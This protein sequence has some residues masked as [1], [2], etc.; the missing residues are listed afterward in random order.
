M[1]ER[2]VVRA[3]PLSVQRERIRRRRLSHVVI[4]RHEMERDGVVDHRAYS[5][6]LVHLRLV[7]G[8][9]NH[10]AADHRERGRDAVDGCYGGG[11]EAGFVREPA[12]GARRL[13]DVQP[14]RAPLGD[15][16]IR[17]L[18]HGREHAE[19][20]IRHLREME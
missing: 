19:L 9:V 17:V 1:L 12:H 6:Q 2:V 14:A 18:A 11:V 13:A 15:V 8:V 10:V 4:P 16:L 3:E 20:R 5:E 7:F